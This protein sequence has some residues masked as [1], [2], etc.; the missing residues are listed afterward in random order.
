MASNAELQLRIALMRE[1]QSSSQTDP[2]HQALLQQLGPLGE[3]VRALTVEKNEW[4]NAV[5]GSVEGGQAEIEHQKK[6]VELYTNNIDGLEARF[7]GMCGGDK[8]IME[9][10]RQECYGNLYRQGEG[11]AELEGT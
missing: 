1:E 9:A 6:E 5:R 2:G 10:L 11:L 4:E 3:E 8:E 7:W